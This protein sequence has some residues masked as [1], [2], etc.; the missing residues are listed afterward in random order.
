MDCDE[1]NEVQSSHA[2]QNQSMSSQHVDE[3]DRPNQFFVNSI[4]HHGLLRNQE[5]MSKLD[6]QMKD[7]SEEP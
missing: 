4:Q 7:E 1:S 6:Q 3:D 5:E 2:L